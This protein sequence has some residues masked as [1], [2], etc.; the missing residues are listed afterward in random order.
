ME[1]FKG[2]MVR[3]VMWN[4][5]V[6]AGNWYGADGRSFRETLAPL[7]LIPITVAAGAVPLQ[8]A[9]LLAALATA[10]IREMP[11]QGN[12]W[13][14][15]SLGSGNAAKD[16]RLTTMVGAHKAASMSVHAGSAPERPLLRVWLAPTWKDCFF[17][18][19]EPRR[20]ERGGWISGAGRI[21]CLTLCCQLL[22]TT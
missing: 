3:N 12:G 2:K 8:G 5:D 10:G 20:C 4:N 22:A 14:V 11:A 7:S 18:I 13:G 21:Q 9:A 19:S 16:S 17:L 15:V 6:V 1:E